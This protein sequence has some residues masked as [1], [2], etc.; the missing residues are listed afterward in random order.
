MFLEPTIAGHELIAAGRTFIHVTT[1]NMELSLQN[2]AVVARNFI[3]MPAVL[4]TSVSN[5]GDRLSIACVIKNGRDRIANVAPMV[6]VS[7]DHSGHLTVG[8]NV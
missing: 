3:C 7:Q 4:F 5:A 8:G 1:G 6:M 2:S